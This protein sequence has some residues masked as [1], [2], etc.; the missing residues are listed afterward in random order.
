M[1]TV[2]LAMVA[3]VLGGGVGAGGGAFLLYRCAPADGDEAAVVR[4]GEAAVVREDDAASVAEDEA[5]PDGDTGDALQQAD[6]PSGTMGLAAAEA[7]LA[8]DVEEAPDVSDLPAEEGSA[9]VDE[10]G[11]SPDLDAFSD[12][13][14]GAAGSVAVDPDPT[15][16]RR[17]ARIFSNMRPEQAAAVM[18]ELS[19]EEARRILLSMSERAA[20]GIL[21]QMETDRAAVLSQRVLGVGGGVR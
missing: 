18:V 9:D 8:A 17:L 14:A 6:A 3:L 12:P 5:L 19:D 1:K 4:D 10:A 7:P 11:A 13:V 16:L 20:A 21:G 2:V 15:S